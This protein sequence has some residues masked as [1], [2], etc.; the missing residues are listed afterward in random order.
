MKN[1]R[2]AAMVR[3]RSEQMSAPQWAKKLGFS[4]KTVRARIE[5]GIPLDAPQHPGRNPLAGTWNYVADREMTPKAK[6]SVVSVSVPAPAIIFTD[7]LTPA[8]AKPP[9]NA[10]PTPVKPN[11]TSRHGRWVELELADGRFITFDP[12]D[13]VGCE[14]AD[15]GAAITIHLRGRGCA[16]IA[17]INARALWRYITEAAR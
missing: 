15:G 9:P 10:T 3:F 8:G 16:F 14:T 5:A 7:D 1:G 12:I 4:T 13:V 2:P 6:R 11:S 17:P